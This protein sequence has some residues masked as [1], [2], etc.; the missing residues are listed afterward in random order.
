MFRTVKQIRS[1]FFKFDTLRKCDVKL[2]HVST[3]APRCNILILFGK[4]KCM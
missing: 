4:L 1:P 3:T 2:L